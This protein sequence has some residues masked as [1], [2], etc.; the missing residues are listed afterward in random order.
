MNLLLL[1]N[2]TQH[3]RGY[4]EHALDTVTGF[5][6]AGARLAFV[7]YALAD[8]PGYTARV[9]TAL[10]PAGITVRGVH[11]NADPVAELAASDAVFIG[12]GNSFRLLSA[13]Y[14]TG[15]RTAVAEAVRDGLP[16]MGASAGTNMAAPTLRTSNDMPI[17]QPPSFE[18]LGLV[19]FQ[20]N[21]HYL[22][23]D[24]AST[25][26]GETREERLTEFLEENDA[27]VLGL[28]E[29]SWLHVA[30]HR[31]HVQG[32]SPARLFTR[33]SEPQ[34]LPVG[35]DVSRLLR[36]EPRYDAPAR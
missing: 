29:G 8:Y 27:P 13:L 34:E 10:E 14:R 7:P 3:G 11:E 31:A 12:G 18:T 33:G 20:I 6:P 19:P 28:R 17:V 21:P 30:G 26:K 15:L 5:L 36:T 2:S 22:D 16:Y 25:H 23:P 35:A 9:R 32:A 1:S 24:P 4:L